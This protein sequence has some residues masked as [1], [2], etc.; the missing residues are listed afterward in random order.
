M[1][2]GKAI[3]DWIKEDPLLLIDFDSLPP[4]LLYRLQREPN[5]FI[6]E[7]AK[8][9]EQYQKR[10]EKLKA[11]CQAKIDKLNSKNKLVQGLAKENWNAI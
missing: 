5:E 3:I 2:N 9:Q 10:I 1:I 8:K 7:D 11:N 6:G 4:S